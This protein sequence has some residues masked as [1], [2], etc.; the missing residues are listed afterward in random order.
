MWD[1]EEATFLIKGRKLYYDNK[2]IKGR[3]MFIVHVHIVP[4]LST[5]NIRNFDRKLLSL[6][7]TGAIVYTIHTYSI[8]FTKSTSKWL[9]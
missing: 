8:G 9:D 4:L 5:T 6:H 1:V 3:R 7:F 2:A